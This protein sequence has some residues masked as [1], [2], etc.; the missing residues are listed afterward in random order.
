MHVSK[1]SFLCS[2]PPHPVPMAAVYGQRLLLGCEQ[3]YASMAICQ[4]NR[5]STELPIMQR[6]LKRNRRMYLFIRVCRKHLF[7][8]QQRHILIAQ[9]YVKIP[10]RLVVGTVVLKVE[11]KIEKEV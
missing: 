4:I 1:G 10:F 2:E 11:I 3:Y 8:W 5:Y 9:R 6:S 7:A